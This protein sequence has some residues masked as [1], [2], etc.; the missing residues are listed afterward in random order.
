MALRRG[1]SE[2]IFSRMSN[3]GRRW[4]LPFAP[5][6]AALIVGWI[7]GAAGGFCLGLWIGA[8]I[9]AA[10]SLAVTCATLAWF[11]MVVLGAAWERRP[12]RKRRPTFGER[13]ETNWRAY[14]RK[15]FDDEIAEERARDRQH[16]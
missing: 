7:G 9:V 11:W 5:D 13:L 6:D 12:W 4:P 16:L 10:C 2:R 1:R 3:A 8:G 14:L 15:R